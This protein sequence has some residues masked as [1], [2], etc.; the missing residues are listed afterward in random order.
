MEMYLLLDKM[1]GGLDV[2]AGGLYHLGESRVI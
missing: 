2:Q 1:Y